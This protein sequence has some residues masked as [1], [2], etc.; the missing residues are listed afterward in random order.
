MPQALHEN[1]FISEA[2]SLS[3]RELGTKECFSHQVPQQ[4]YQLGEKSGPVEPESQRS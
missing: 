2:G 1:K 4:N 3:S